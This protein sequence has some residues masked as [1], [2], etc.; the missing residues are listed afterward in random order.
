M[1][2]SVLIVDDEETLAK[3]VKA[4]LT[5]YGYAAERAGS[6][7]EGIAILDTLKPDLLLLDLHLPD[8]NGLEV[9]KR[10]RAQAPEVKVII[11]TGAGS[12]Q[13]AVDAMKAG[14]YDYLSKPLVLKE[15][16][17]LLDQAVG[18]GQIETALAYY[19]SKE[20]EISGL[21]RLWGESP[22][23]CEMKQRIARIVEQE[24][25]LASG[26]PPSVLI[27]GETGTGKELVARAFHFEG[28]RRDRPF[29]AI[30]C[31][32]I[33]ADLIEAELFGFERGAF[34]DAKARKLGLAEA[35][36][37]GTLFLDEIGDLGTAVQ[38]KLLRLIE[39]KTVR[40]LGSVHGHEVDVRI[41]AATNADLRQKVNSGEF[42]AD[43]FFRL[44]TIH[45]EIPPLRARGDDIVLLARN[46]L[47]GEAKR[48]GKGEL[49]FTRKAEEV[50]RRYAWPGNVRELRNVVEHAVLL[51]EGTYIDDGSLMLNPGLASGTRAAEA[52]ES[53]GGLNLVLSEVTLI[54]Q[55]LEQSDWNVTK[56]ARILGIS[57][58]TLRYRME[59]Y[60]IR[61]P[62]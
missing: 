52:V 50:L 53:E 28:P 29:V 3:N 61:P 20:A 59:K 48:Y 17:L 34:T 41:I 42:R 43:L 16:K 47:R 54:T 5:R 14:A 62:G 7:E 46:H 22:L 37:G 58:D 12:V 60:E 26:A 33:P 4:Y 44:C 19:Q 49:R 9:L 55:A 15:V 32:A 30:N 6:G 24:K 57:R 25:R 11:I 2:H 10:V 40:R 13:D 56:A 38:G 45:I 27:T 8:I 39:D 31:T 36:N 51:C 18:R 1:A 23:I 21:A 35:A